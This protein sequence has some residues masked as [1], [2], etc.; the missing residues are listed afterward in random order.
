[1]LMQ[2]I[3]ETL[4]GALTGY[5]T[6]H[7]AIRS[8]FRPGGVVEQTRDDFAREAGRLLEDQVLTRAVLEQQLQL[9]EVQQILA[10]A[11]ETFLQ[12]TLSD[13]FAEKR[14]GDLPGSEESCA[15]LQRQLLQFLQQEQDTL[16]H[17]WKKQ[18]DLSALLDQQQAEL[19]CQQLKTLLLNTVEQQQLAE[20]VWQ[21]WQQEKGQL[22]LEQL[23]L[24]PFCQAVITNLA[25]ESRQWPAQ[26]QAQYGEELER[27]LLQSIQKVQLRPILLELDQ[28]MEQY[29]LGQYFRGEEAQLAAVLQEKLTGAEG[30]ALLNYLAE[31]LLAALAK[32][33]VPVSQLLPGELMVQLE[34]L[35]QQ[36]I[37]FVLQQLLDWLQQNKQAV[38][39]MLE[40]AVDEVAQE[41]GGMKGMLLQQLKDGLL[42]QAVQQVDFSAF[43]QQLSEQESS[44]QMAALL[45][46]KIRAALQEQTLGAWI[47]RWQQKGQL[48]T[49]LPM[50][51]TRL[52]GQLHEEQLGRILAWK[53]GSLQ[54]AQHQPQIEQWLVKLLLG[55]IQQMD[56][57]ALLQQYGS[58][59]Q[60]LSLPELMRMKPE[61]LADF[62]R[63][64]IA[65]GCDQLP[66]DL[67]QLPATV[68]WNAVYDGV[69]HIWEQQ[70]EKW[71]LQ[72]AEQ[73]SLKE[74]VQT[75]QPAV[76][77]Y[78]ERILSGLTALGM[79]FA[80][81][82]LSVLAQRQIGALSND[83]MLKLVENFMGQE[84]QPLNY[85][86]AGMGAVAGATVGTALA[87]AVPV[88][89]AG[90]AMLLSVLAGKS[91]VFGAV[92]YATNCAAV[93]GLFWPY[94]PVAGIDALQGVIPKQKQRFAH[95]MGQMVDRYV[96]NEAVLQQLLEQSKPK[97]L[98]YSTSLA[99]DTNK[100]E[101]GV[102]LLVQQRSHFTQYLLSRLEQSGLKQSQQW[103]ESLGSMPL[104]FLQN[105]SVNGNAVRQER[106]L[107]WLQ[108]WG[109]EKLRQDIA[110]T[111]IFSG[112]QLWQQLLTWLSE[113]PVLD[114]SAMAERFCQREQSLARWMSQQEQ[115][116]L[117]Y[118]A[119]Q[120]VQQWMAQKGHQQ[121][122]AVMLGSVMQ[123][124]RIRQWL[125]EHSHS[126][127]QEITASL[128]K[129]AQRAILELLQSKQ[130]TLTAAVQKSIL[131]RM[132]LMQQMGYTMMGGDEI[133]ERIVERVL[134]QKL[135]IFLS[136]KSKE[137]QQVFMD[138]WQQRLF[139]ALLQVPLQQ[140]QVEALAQQLL[141]QPVV[142][143]AAG[144][145]AGRAVAL[146]MDMPVKQWGSR[147]AL[148]PLLER[149]QMQLG[150]QWQINGR[151]AL[152]LWQPLAMEIYNR[153]GAALTLATLTKGMHGEVPL[154]EILQY[155]GLSVQ[156]NAFQMRL[157]ENMA[158]TRLQQWLDWPRAAQQLQAG[159]EG[160]V[161]DERFRQWLSYEGQMVV[162]NLAEQ[163]QHIL[164][165]AGRQAILEPVM[166]AAL[167]TGQQYGGRLL[168]AMGLS[169]L[170]ETQLA[171]MDSA[172]LEQVVWGF[173]SQYLVH[174]ENRGW[175]GAAFALP[176]MLIYLL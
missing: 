94:Q 50:A 89:A 84:L 80:Q 47:E 175:L 111:D 140:Q 121:N 36:E 155:E 142:H 97:W 151:E 21:G 99:A 5:V 74:L 119:E 41:Y 107:Q 42:E 91:A 69:E 145:M 100:L 20:Q 141:E 68:C 153:H 126:W 118:G 172:H 27:L 59:L 160:L 18:F 61:Q 62:L 86:G 148:K 67:A 109:N 28:Q 149:V 170:T 113:Q 37:P 76:Q 72:K 33:D 92:G 157:R 9:P 88:T 150:F 25:R 103:L 130:A 57:S 116:Q 49:L 71:L 159:L 139:P 22:S 135:P 95:S 131:N 133:V 1:M 6:N 163:W 48:Q 13:A 134:Q 102:A 117:I 60:K 55:Q 173:G 93:K 90:P 34:P 12:Q 35:L 165:Q 147:L 161:Q 158:V 14:L 58:Q 38:Q 144:R 39:Q 7:T 127:M 75:L 106:L 154:A 124:E 123:P 164:P 81:G 129:L 108:T 77:P 152:A 166:L 64:M 73:C 83:D 51:F 2:M 31:E 66:A 70:G 8:L 167:Q 105:V 112:Q 16:V 168:S 82:H 176:G 52:L 110:L 46:E 53:P 24:G 171:A 146:C 156:L 125:Q 45:L 17:L 56:L 122:A 138:C 87:V 169:A 30:Q 26:L 104:A 10:E 78:Q 32:V 15:C 162:I 44:E 137:L 101:Q 19:I 114:L 132:G 40:Q 174:I 98:A 85:L 4:L 3:V 143:Q 63:Q 23:G 120:Q 43:L 54:L 115:E 128:F 29:T 136:V 79:E 96:I 65:Q 11:L